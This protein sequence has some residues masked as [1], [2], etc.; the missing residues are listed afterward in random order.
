MLPDVKNV[1]F[2]DGD[3]L[4]AVRRAGGVTPHTIRRMCHLAQAAQAANVDVIFSACSSLGPALDVARQLVD[5][6]KLVRS[7]P[8]TGQ[9]GVLTIGLILILEFVMPELSPYGP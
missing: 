6:P 9:A 7:L 4:A 2:V 5:M 3:L 1:D 8:R